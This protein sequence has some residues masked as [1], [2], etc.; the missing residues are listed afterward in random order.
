M[1]SA[2]QIIYQL[3]IDL[4]LA[5]ELDEDW[6]IYISFLPDLP[7]VALAVYDTAGTP[8]G[9][10]M[11]GPKIEHPGI[12][13]TIRNPDYRE[14]FARARAI[15]DA[16]DNQVNVVVAVESDTS[17]ILHNISRQGTIIPVGIDERD[18]QR[19]HYFTINAIVTFAAES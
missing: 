17:Y 2:A 14:G 9:R 5:G 13:I 4:G 1:S 8:D 16:L 11:D 19:R 18:G 3:L 10:I 15:A 7:H 12:Q 6:P